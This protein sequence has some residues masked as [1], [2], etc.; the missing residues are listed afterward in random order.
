MSDT[1][2]Y[3]MSP[4]HSLDFDL[5]ESRD[6][7]VEATEVDLEQEAPGDDVTADMI[8]ADMQTP[9]S[10]L[11]YNKG[12]EQAG[13]SPADRLNPE[14]VD[15]LSHEYTISE[16]ERW[17]T[18]P[19]VVPGDP[20]VMYFTHALPQRVQAVNGRTGETYWTFTYQNEN[21]V[22]QTGANRGAAVYGDKI[23]LAAYDNNLVAIDRYTGEMQWKTRTLSPRQ[24]NEM[25]RPDR[26]GHTSAPVVFDGIVMKGMAGVY[27]GWGAISALDAETGDILWQHDVVPK[28][29]WVGETWRYGDS[30]P[31]N[32]ASIDPE[33][34]QVFFPTGNP[35]AIYAPYARPGPNR[36][37]NSVIAVDIDSGEIQWTT[38]FIPH[39]W[40]DYDTYN[41]RVMDIEVGGET[42]RVVQAANKTGWLYFMDAETGKLIERTKPY[43][44]QGGEIPFL[45]WMP[46]GEANK[47]S[48]YPSDRGA[49]EWTP[50]SYSPDTG[51]VHV[52][53]NDHGRL[54]YWEQ[55]DYSADPP[56]VDTGNPP[57]YGEKIEDLSDQPDI[58]SRLVAIDPSTGE[59]VWR[60]EYE[61]S[62]SD[63][64]YAR[65][66]G[67]TATGGN[68]VF[69]GS[70]NG[71]LVAVNAQTGDLLWEDSVTDIHRGITAAP[72]TWDDP[73]AGKQYVAI[74]SQDG[75]AVYSGGA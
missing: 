3:N 71:N 39:D 57:A 6:V 47:A 13:Y 58:Q 32:N 66:G 26:M 49:T 51:Y 4:K 48:M 52:S 20:P 2:K 42:R 55:W 25:T 45:G 31:W 17:Q 60:H 10:W 68:L 34:R 15:T 37:S 27:G 33:S 64:G 46:H 70:S 21:M 24:L 43:A 19:I 14:T 16:Y 69:G 41:T 28:R 11:T 5:S 29:G 72:L 54:Y 12:P 62:E 67:S 56:Q 30:S 40:S 75:I 44:Q 50:D 35:G 23:Y 63:S 18:Q 8:E 65:A 22:G 38:Q 36:H 1:N 7:N 74:A 73:G 61:V 53:A 9:E 59:E